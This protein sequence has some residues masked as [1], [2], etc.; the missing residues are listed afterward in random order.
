[1]EC[2]VQGAISSEVRLLCSLSPGADPAWSLRHVGSAMRGAGADVLPAQ[3][4]PS[5]EVHISEN[6]LPFLTAVG[7][8]LDHEALH[9]GFLFSFYRATWMK[10]AVTSVHRLPKLHA[11]D[12]AVPL[13]PGLHLVDL[14]APATADNYSDVSAALAAFAEFLAPLVKLSKP[15]TPA[16]I[17]PTAG[18]AAAAVG[19]PRQLASC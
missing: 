4:R 15:G 13:T 8:R 1:M 10:V 14:T 7:F 3:I 18:T 16:G 11:V 19:T 2:A 17:V 5:L 6:A 12:E 9:T